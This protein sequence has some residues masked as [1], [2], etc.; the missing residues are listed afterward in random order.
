VPDESWTN[1]PLGPAPSA[2]LKVWRTLN[3][4][5]VVIRQT[6]PLVL[7]EPPLVP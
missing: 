7:G 6:V 5:W 1:P 4:P 2:P 3:E